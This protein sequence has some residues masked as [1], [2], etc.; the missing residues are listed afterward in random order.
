MV[1]K[2]MKFRQYFI[3]QFKIAITAKSNVLNTV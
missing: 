1:S 3:F 2:K